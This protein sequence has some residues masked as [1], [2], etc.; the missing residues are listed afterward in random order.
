MHTNIHGKDM[1]HL[2]GIHNKRVWNVY[3]EK[4]KK[5]ITPELY[6]KQQTKQKQE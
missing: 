1:N 6:M 3:K 5:E 4:Q 2:D